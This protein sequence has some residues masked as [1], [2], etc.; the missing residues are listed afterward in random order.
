MNAPHYGEWLPLR[1][2]LIS[3]YRGRPG[4]LCFQF[5]PPG[6]TA[7]LVYRGQAEVVHANVSTVARAGQ[8]LIPQPIFRV[9]RFSPDIDFLSLNFFAHWPTGEVAFNPSRA[10]VLDSCRHP[11]MEREALAVEELLGAI[12]RCHGYGM[13]RQ[14]MSIQSYLDVQ[15]LFLKFL[16]AFA[17]ALESVGVGARPPGHLDP[18]LA[19]ALEFIERQP[20][21]LALTLAQVARAAGISPAHLNRL[22]VQHLGQSVLRYHERRRG[23]YARRCLSLPGTQ[24]KQVAIALGFSTPGHFSRWFTRQHGL[25]PRQF[26]SQPRLA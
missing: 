3:C 5:L 8:W 12:L 20:Q 14:E 19:L 6:L 4:N 1:T 18:R 26:Q 24:V 15:Q 23:E 25:S 13:Y 17:A 11:E 16:K 7:W 9:Q 10:V 22:A 21:N 2:A